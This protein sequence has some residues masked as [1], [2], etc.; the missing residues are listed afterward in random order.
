MIF[1]QKCGGEPIH[2]K[3]L[4]H[5]CIKRDGDRRKRREQERYECGL[6]VK[7]GDVRE[8]DR[9]RNCLSCR[10]KYRE[11]FDVYH[12]YRNSKPEGE[13]VEPTI[14][15]YGD[16]EIERRDC[17]PTT[18]TPGSE[19]KVQ[20]L[21]NRY[22]AGEWLFHPQDEWWFQTSRQSQYVADRD[23]DVDEWDDF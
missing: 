3:R 1:C 6:C 16:V 19:E 22:E 9:F 11:K 14:D 2:G 15:D 17:Q 23:D 18:A 8:D 4:C 13:F 12:T 7:C 10:I 20:V 21:M 5:T